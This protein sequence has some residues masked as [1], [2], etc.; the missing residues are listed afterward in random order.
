MKSVRDSIV[1]AIERIERDID[2][3]LKDNPVGSKMSSA[4]DILLCRNLRDLAN[5]H[6]ES[7]AQ[8]AIERVKQKITSYQ[9]HIDY[10]KL[11]YGDK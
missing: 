7:L 5:Y 2:S 3:L 8:E 4:G 10:F 1:D 11:V 6:G 9:K